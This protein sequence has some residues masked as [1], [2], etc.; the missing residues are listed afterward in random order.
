MDNFEVKTPCHTMTLSGVS[1]TSSIIV[2]FTVGTEAPKLLLGPKK[3]KPLVNKPQHSVP[4]DKECPKE[5]VTNH[6]LSCWVVTG[7]YLI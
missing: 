2:A 3:K 7:T 1:F 6:G 4:L 5:K